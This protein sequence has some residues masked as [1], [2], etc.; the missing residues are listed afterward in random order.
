MQ[1]MRLIVAVALLTCVQLVYARDVN[2]WGPF[3]LGMTI[4]DARR[5]SGLRWAPQAQASQKDERAWT[6]T[7]I[8]PYEFL[9]IL[10]F[11]DHR[12]LGSFSF[13]NYVTSAEERI[14]CERR[15]LLVLSALEAKEGRFTAR[16]G[17]G[18]GSELGVRRALGKSRYSV[19]TRVHEVVEQI[20]YRPGPPD[21]LTTFAASRVAG[22][23]MATIAAYYTW[24]PEGKKGN[25]SCSIHIGYCEGVCG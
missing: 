2:G 14:D 4:E 17:N 10:Y 1:L 6:Q 13:H 15:F 3:S 8:G 23:R 11:Y 20:A 7:T 22:G 18:A 21:W 24:P 16:L 19:S 5:I 9:T 25:Q 12:R